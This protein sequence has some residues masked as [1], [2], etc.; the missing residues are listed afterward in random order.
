MKAKYTHARGRAVAHKQ[1]RM[2]LIC[3]LTLTIMVVVTAVSAVSGA[4]TPS[5]HQKTAPR[6]SSIIFCSSQ[7]DKPY[8]RYIWNNL[9]IEVDYGTPDDCANKSRLW[10]HVVHSPLR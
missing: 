7:A 5:H 6:K 3:L 2:G 9:S 8:M 1:C 10:T 4:S